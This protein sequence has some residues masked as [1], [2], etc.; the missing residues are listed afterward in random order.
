MYVYFQPLITP[1]EIKWFIDVIY[2]GGLKKPNVFR[3]N[4][5]DKY[6]VSIFKKMYTIFSYSYKIEYLFKILIVSHNRRLTT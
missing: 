6:E 1:L 2:F 4:L 3:L 5:T